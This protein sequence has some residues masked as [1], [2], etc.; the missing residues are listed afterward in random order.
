M[1]LSSIDHPNRLFIHDKPS[2]KNA[3]HGTPILGGR[4]SGAAIKILSDDWILADFH[5]GKGVLKR[6]CI[7][8]HDV[9]EHFFFIG[10]GG[11]HFLLRVEKSE[12]FVAY[13]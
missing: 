7:G 10:M 8:S 4:V 3:A 11:L 13:V 9:M 2:W 12:V 1:I 5:N 6:K